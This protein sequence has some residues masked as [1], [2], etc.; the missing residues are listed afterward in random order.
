MARALGFGS[1]QVTALPFLGE[2]PASLPHA[3]NCYLIETERSVV[4]VTADSAVRQEQA[5]LLAERLEAG[6]R[7]GLLLGRDIHADGSMDAGWRENRG[8]LLNPIRLWSW[9]A[10]VHSWF[11]PAWP[12]GMSE[13]SAR[14]LVAA[15]LRFMFPYAAGATPWFR[16]HDPGHFFRAGVGSMSVGEFRAF[17]RRAAA[18]GLAIPPL[19]YGV[20]L[21]QDGGAEPRPGRR[22]RGYS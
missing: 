17:E 21:R 20:P 2:F 16:F 12:L 7:V 9:Y 19:R 1:V 8:E 5:A 22:C 6:R 3:W 10:P 11:A 18:V 13:R 4:A 15:G 14:E